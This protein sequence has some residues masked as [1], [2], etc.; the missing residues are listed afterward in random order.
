MATLID[1]Y[2]ESNYSQDIDLSSDV[3]QEAQ[4]F[5]GNGD[6]ITSCRFY[7]KKSG[8]PTGNLYAKIY[9]HSGVYGTSSVPTGGPLATSDALDIST[10][11]TSYELVEFTFSTPY[12]TIG[13]TNYVLSLEA[14]TAVSVYI[15]V[16]NVS[17]SHSGNRSYN[18]L[19]MGWE[20]D[21]TRDICFYVYG[22]ENLETPTIGESYPLPPFRRA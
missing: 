18:F 12:A 3:Q 15:G 21:N 17:P 16:D 1:S 2:S 19:G 4:S 13:D 5:T 8:T 9:T 11:S 6:S 22:V 14:T 20:K 10:L 7:L